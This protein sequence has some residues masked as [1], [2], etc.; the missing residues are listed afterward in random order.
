M[1]QDRAHPEFRVAVYDLWENKIHS[2]CHY[3]NNSDY[4]PNTLSQMHVS[5]LMPRQSGGLSTCGFSCFTYKMHFENKGEKM[6]KYIAIA[7][8]IFGLV[9]T[10]Q[11]ED[12][13]P[14]IGGGA[15]LAF[16]DIGKTVPGAGT[17]SVGVGYGSLGFDY[18]DF[19]GAE[20]RLG[21]TGTTSIA[22]G[23]LTYDATIDWFASYLAKLQ[24]PV[25]DQFRVYA[26]GGATTAKTT[27]TI[28]TPGWFFVATGTPSI[29][30]TT[31]SGSFG[32]GFDFRASDQLHIGAEWM[33]VG[34]DVSS[35]TA[36]LKFYF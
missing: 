21:T 28:T 1:T 12:F 7:A 20:V 27:V 14:Y 11:A 36:N 25:T 34:S 4:T 3:Q 29:S 13:K 19:I 10:A 6:R 35:A 9:Q 15:G 32:A 16:F 30:D 23:G 24:Y 31:T 33:K 22:F 26:M 5:T 2:S 18:G 8:I 17:K